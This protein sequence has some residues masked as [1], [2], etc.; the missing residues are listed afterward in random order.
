MLCRGAS[1]PLRSV[2]PAPHHTLAAACLSAGCCPANC[3]C[4]PETSAPCSPRQALVDVSA[5]Q[6]A[7]LFL[8]CALGFFEGL[9]TR[10]GLG[11]DIRTD[12]RLQGT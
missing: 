3:T 8:P 7:L 6:L 12:G 11:Q 10:A 1:A 2:M 9:M 4:P 5:A